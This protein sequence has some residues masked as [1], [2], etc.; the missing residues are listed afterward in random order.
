MIPSRTRRS[1][2]TPAL[3]ALCSMLLA[4]ALGAPV[5]AQVLSDPRMAEFDPSPDHWVTLE[6]GQPAVM[7]YEL[8]VYLIGASSPFGT[9]DMGKPD[10]EAD[11]KI[12]F[13][14][15]SQVAAWQLPGGD[16][17]ARVSAV[18]PEGAALSDPSNPFTFS[19]GNPC[20]TALSATAG[21]APAAGGNY[22]VDVTTGEG[23]QWAATTAAPWLTL[24]TA[25]GSGSGTVAFAVQANTAYTGRAGTIDIGGQSLTITQAAAPEPCSYSLSASSASVP[26]SG[27]SVSF[28]VIA[29][30]GCAWTA[31]TASSWI[32]LA[33]SGGSGGGTVSLTVGANTSAATRSGTVTVQGQTFTITQAGVAASCSYGVTP[34]SASFSSAGG[35]GSITVTTGGGCAW[36]VA[37]T[38][39]WLVPSVTG[40]TNAGTFAFT[41]KVNNGTTSRSAKL[42]VGPW[43]VTVSQSGKPRRK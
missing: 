24:L 8:G 5:Q 17:E 10:P 23:C 34:P 29:G 31:A 20:T 1:I 38:Q 28:S 6:G 42:N 12:R 16:Y 43:A 3:T 27:G 36:A 41:V 39:S 14:F 4:L 7:R 35:T 13:D 21:S 37:S 40:G 26:A 19:T 9:V 11:G 15:A 22:A 18:G 30:G 32:T 25:G 33:G 2:V